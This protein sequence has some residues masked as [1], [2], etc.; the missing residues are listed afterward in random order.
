MICLLCRGAYLLF[1]LITRM[2]DITTF[3]IFFD[4][5]RDGAELKSESKKRDNKPGVLLA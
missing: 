5:Y 3:I 1:D 2:H 4:F